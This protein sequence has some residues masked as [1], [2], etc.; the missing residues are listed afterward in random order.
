[1]FAVICSRGSQPPM[2]LTGRAGLPVPVPPGSPLAAFP[3][4]LLVPRPTD[5]SDGFTWKFCGDKYLPVSYARSELGFSCA[6][7]K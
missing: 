3:P 5:K 1:M 2:A 6:I 4:L 7:W